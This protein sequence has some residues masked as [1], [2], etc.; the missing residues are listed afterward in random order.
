MIL[1]FDTVRLANVLL[2]LIL[3]CLDIGQFKPLEKSKKPKRV[4]PTSLTLLGPVW[5]EEV[6]LISL[7]NQLSEPLEI[8]AT[9]MS[10]LVLLQLS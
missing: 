10:N 8:K 6:R 2:L 7:K 3:T 4:K 5:T 9:M 1:G